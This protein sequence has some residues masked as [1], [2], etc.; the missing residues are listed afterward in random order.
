MPESPVHTLKTLARAVLHAVSRVVYRLLRL[1]TWP[2]RAWWRALRRARWL[3]RTGLAVFA[4]VIVLLAW[5]VIAVPWPGYLF[6]P[7]YRAVEYGVINDL[8][9]LRPGRVGAG[10]PAE[11]AACLAR[12]QLC[13]TARTVAARGGQLCAETRGA[14]ASIDSQC[15]PGATDATCREGRAKCAAVESACA[16][17]KPLSECRAIESTP[18][19]TG[20]ETWQ[21]WTREDRLR[22]Y[23]HPQGSAQVML[24]QMRYSWFVNLEMA[25]GRARFAAPENMARYGFL[26]DVGQRPDPKWNP[27]NLPVGFTKYYDDVVGAELL[28]FTCSLC[29]T[30]ELH[31]NGTAIRI[32]GGQAMHAVTDM[33]PGQFQA[34]M[35]S[36]LL[37]TYLN[38]W[39]FSR[40]AHNVI[41][42]TIPAGMARDFDFGAARKK[43]RSQFGA[44]IRLLLAD[45]WTDLRHGNYPVFEGYGRTDATQRIA[46]TVFGR[47]ISPD[48]YRP[49]TAPVSYPHLWDISKFNWVQWEGYASQPMARNVNESLGVGARLDLFDEFGAPLPMHL[50]YGTSIQPDRLHDIE[51]T[52]ARLQA[53]AWPEHLF[54]TLDMERARKGRALFDANCRHCHGP[55]VDPADVPPESY[56]QDQ[57][58]AVPLK[59]HNG[60][61][62]T[63][64]VT[65]ECRPEDAACASGREPRPTRDVNLS[66]QQCLNLQNPQRVADIHGNP[67]FRL[68]ANGNVIGLACDPAREDC[69]GRPDHVPEWQ[70]SL[71]PIRDIGTDRNAALNFAYNTYDASRL[72]WTGDELRELCLSEE[73]I[74]AI[75][76][77]KMSAVVGLNIMS[78]SIARR[79]FRDHRPASPEELMKFMGYGILDFPRTD[80][81]RLENYKSRPL[82]GIWATPPFLHNGSVRTVYQ[83]ISPREERDR[84]F[85]SGTKEYDPVHLGYRNLDVPG[86]VRFDTK[87]VG[88]DNVGHEF[89]QGCQK[90]GVIGRYLEPRERLEIMEYLKVMDYTPGDAGYEPALCRDREDKAACFAGIA[91]AQKAEETAHP[92][93][94][95]D[96]FKNSPSERHCSDDDELYGTYLPQ[97]PARDEVWNTW[98]MS[99]KEQCST[100]R[101]LLESEDTPGGR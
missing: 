80:P 40:F 9:Y 4:G 20:E 88:N 39:K 97:A 84:W 35:M 12:Q 79:Y 92:P 61:T 93:W 37:A 5:L 44:T 34:E 48:N 16:A 73:T 43:L 70:L 32:L 99:A 3:G 72:G 75:D 65:D 89:R 28:D 78:L 31:Y 74:K 8:Q 91:D 98:K 71:L 42:P 49:A 81:A 53:P 56:S 68:D 17:D 101:K 86:A 21:G 96:A 14:C 58:I 76:P 33:K 18:C 57:D 55:H 95:S 85:W 11:V 19:A 100:Y 77:K 27:G 6:T 62:C 64:T 54:G 26:T 63:L 94:G 50:R 87:V 1:V 13:A 59:Y 46:N 23:H 36:A 15:P 66:P 7:P 90:S 22:F 29:H 47:H 38:P 45:A 41:D 25:V 24:A 60:G 52:L 67:V 2:V 82:H 30:G 10:T 69:T 83:M 51:R